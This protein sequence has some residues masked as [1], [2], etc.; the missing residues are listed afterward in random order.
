MPLTQ[1]AMQMVCNTTCLLMVV[2]LH[3]S[4]ATSESHLQVCKVKIKY[5]SHHKEADAK[6]KKIFC[7]KFLDILI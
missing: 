2:V 4:L 7:K 1:A 3:K 5:K 6:R